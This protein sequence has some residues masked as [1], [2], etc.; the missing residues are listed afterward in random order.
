[1]TI[2]YII[3]TYY[4]YMIIYVCVCCDPT[5]VIKVTASKPSQTGILTGNNHAFCKQWLHTKLL[6]KP[7]FMWYWWRICRLKLKYTFAVVDGCF[8]LNGI[9]KIR[10]DLF[11][12]QIRSCH[13]SIQLSFH[14]GDGVPWFLLYIRVILPAAR[15]V[16]LPFDG[17]WITIKKHCANREIGEWF[18]CFNL[19]R[20]QA[21]V[22][23]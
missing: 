5:C 23:S 18:D 14:Y 7:C 6:C 10:N 4:I 11:H 16:Y 9:S 20:D 12:V 1:M 15:N 21:F 22:Q 2:N 8:F 13:G 3:F 19:A 17:E